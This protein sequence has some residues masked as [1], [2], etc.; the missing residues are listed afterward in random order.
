M[1]NRFAGAQN[2]AERRRRR[3]AND[4]PS[5]LSPT[6]SQIAAV[7]TVNSF[8]SITGGGAI[9]SQMLRRFISPR[10]WKH[11][12]LLLGL[13]ILGTA[14]TWWS[15]TA[16]EGTVEPSRVL[17][18]MA[19]MLLLLAGQL[20]FLI[21]WI[22]SQSDLDFQGRYR[23]WRWMA[24]AACV[25]ALILLTGT[26][27]LIP[28]LLVKVVESATGPIQ[29]ARPAVLFVFVAVFGL[30][31]L[32]RVLPDMGRCLYS[33]ALLAA[34]MLTTVVQ[35]MLVHGA[36]QSSIQSETLNAMTLLAAWATFA[37]M[38]LHCRF[39]AFVCGAPPVRS[40]SVS[41]PV[42]SQPTESET[43]STVDPAELVA[44]VEI[45]PKKP[46]RK[47]KTSRKRRAA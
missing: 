47:S 31:V 20:A 41:E 11:V 27:S 8:S 16:G 39:V 42:A 43:T 24:A 26:S 21:G 5:A 28:Q 3:L 33:Q 1:E 12:V 46:A 13:A 2:Q 19:G 40:T 23:G 10:L 38:L 7:G 6:E 14:L 30:S 37:S 35:L 17:E 4:E 34:A 22:R 44:P 9:D 36:S 25:L 29:A 45:P 18:G 15:R 32:A